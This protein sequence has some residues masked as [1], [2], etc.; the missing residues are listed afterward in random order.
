[1]DFVYASADIIISRAGASSVSELS[2]VGKPVILFPSLMWLNHQTKT[3]KLLLIKG[4]LLLKESE[5][6]SQFS[7]VFE[8][9]LKTKESKVN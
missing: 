9:L 8:A 7:V 4:A 2:I 6:E 5:L 1:M 3:L